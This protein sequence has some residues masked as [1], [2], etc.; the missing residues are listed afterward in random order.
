V[1]DA[2]AKAYS[3]LMQR[4]RKEIVFGV[5]RIEGKEVILAKPKSYMNLSGP[6]VHRLCRE[7]NL[8][9]EA[10]LVIH[11]DIDLAFGNIKIKE[12]GGHGGHNG[13]RSLMESLGSD[14]FSRIRI[15][16]GRPETEASVTDFVLGDFGPEET[17]IL[18]QV[19]QRAKEAVICILSHG[20]TEGMNR[21]NTNKTRVSR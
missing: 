2:L 13:I 1:V 11:D 7:M 21:F 6:P 10:V 19:I 8:S 18:D 3:I 14:R 20:T 5:G 15:G 9:S 4:R 17:V 16:I 12:K